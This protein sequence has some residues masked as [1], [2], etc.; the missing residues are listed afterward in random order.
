LKV[1]NNSELSRFLMDNCE[2][3]TERFD[4]LNWRKVNS[5]KYP[6]LSKLVK[7]VLVVQVSTVASK[8]AFS[9][10]GRVIS[11]FVS[12]LSAKMVESLICAQSWLLTSPKDLYIEE[13]IKDLHNCEKLEE[14]LLQYVFVPTVRIPL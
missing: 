1:E 10:G 8:T 13:I 2:K 12:S 3:H 7:D 11:S 5:S 6:I 14:A 4:I 9:T